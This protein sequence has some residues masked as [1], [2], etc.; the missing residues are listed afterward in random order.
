MELF[1]IGAGE[2]LLILALALVVLG[3]EKLPEVAG[4]I[5][6]TVADFRRQASELT[7]EFQRGLDTASLERKEQRIAPS[8]VR[9]GP[10]CTSCGAQSTAEA[11]YCASCGASMSAPVADGERRE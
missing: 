4:Q 5:G 2:L 8:T 1:G 7:S 11:R 9:T 3:P 6:R 10:Y